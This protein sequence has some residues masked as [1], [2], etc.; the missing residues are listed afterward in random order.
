MKKSRIINMVISEYNIGQDKHYAV[1]KEI[2]SVIFAIG[3]DNKKIIDM[4][5]WFFSLKW[6]F[7]ETMFNRQGIYTSFTKFVLDFRNAADTMKF[8]EKIFKEDKRKI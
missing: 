2:T 4:Y 7:L 1:K 8:L 5:E 6:K 3:I